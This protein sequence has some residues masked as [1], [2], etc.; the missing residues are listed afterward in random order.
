MSKYHNVKTSTLRGN[1]DSKKEALYE[2]ELFL[3]L[4]AKEIEGYECQVKFDISVKNKHI[5]NYVADFVVKTL[6]GTFEVRE[7]KG[8]KAI[9]TS[10]FRLKFKLMK[11]LYPEYIFRI[12]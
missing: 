5:C 4:K 2:E 11:A 12:V 3:S 10:T 7:V 6:D 1:F 9:Q 8:G